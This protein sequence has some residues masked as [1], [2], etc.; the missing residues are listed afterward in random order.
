MRLGFSG[1][2]GKYCVGKL[3]D[4]E[5]TNIIELLAR[6]EPSL[7]LTLQETTFDTHDFKTEYYD[8]DDVYESETVSLPCD[9]TIDELPTDCKSDLDD[10]FTSDDLTVVVNTEP[11]LKDGFYLTSTAEQKGNFFTINIDVLPEEFDKSLLRI[12][13]NDLD[14]FS[15]SDIVIQ[16]IYYDG[17]TVDFDT[18]S[19]Y[20]DDNSFSQSILYVENGTHYDGI[21]I[22]KKRV[23]KSY[24]LIDS[25]SSFGN[26]DTEQYIQ[27]YLEFVE[28]KNS[29]YLLNKGYMMAFA[30]PML[31]DNYEKSEVDEL[32]MT[33][34][35]IKF[36][37][38]HNLM[39][40]M[41]TDVY[42]RIIGRFPEW[43]I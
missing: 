13:G 37:L 11:T 27:E 17:R 42:D 24:P 4:N 32:W 33:E 14:N 3:T 16:D 6:F 43:L 5:I 40:S 20:T 21:E 18:D 15:M 1:Y 23:Q 39:D 36:V 38:K 7:F 30:S 28:A 35:N 26:L 12:Y 9:I 41:P 25:F 22:M 2:G 19:Y 34:E 29:G 31:Y 10:I 8:F